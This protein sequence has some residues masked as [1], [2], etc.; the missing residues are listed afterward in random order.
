VFIDT[1][2]NGINPSKPLV[3][4]TEV[5]PL[6]TDRHVRQHNLFIFLHPSINN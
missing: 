6:S 5:S 1:S 3:S 4:P 2:K